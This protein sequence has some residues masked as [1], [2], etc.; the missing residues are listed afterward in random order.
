MSAQNPQFM[1]HPFPDNKIPADRISS[2]AAIDA[3]AIHAAAESDDG[4]GR[5][6]DDDGPA[7]GGRLGQ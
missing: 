6:D 4:H 3:G 5:W 2:G 7:Y 1:R